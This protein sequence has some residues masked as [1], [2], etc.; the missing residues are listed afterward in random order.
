MISIN[1]NA[2]WSGHLGRILVGLA[3]NFQRPLHQWHVRHNSF[4]FHSARGG[5]HHLGLTI[6]QPF[7][8]FGCGKATKDDRMNGT[9]ARAGQHADDGF[10]GGWAIN[11]DAVAGLDMEFILQGGG[12]HCDL[13]EELAIGELLLDA[14]RQWGIINESHLV[15]PSVLNVNVQAIVG[16]V[17]ESIGE[18]I[19]L[20]WIVLIQNLSGFLKPVEIL[21]GPFPEGDRISHRLVIFFLIRAMR[22]LDGVGR[23][24]T[25]DR[26]QKP[27]VIRLG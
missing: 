11:H 24:E 21:S 7:G 16:H 6:L 9:N 20:L 2:P 18:P 17:D 8:Q 23:E 10:R 15:A 19:G 4:G 1:H 22:T 3:R 12:Q 14:A 13:F 26:M 5:N 27:Q 25:V